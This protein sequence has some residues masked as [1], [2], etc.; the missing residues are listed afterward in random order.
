MHTHCFKSNTGSPELKQSAL[1]LAA[2]MSIFI[3][4]SSDVLTFFK[5]ATYQIKRSVSD[6]CIYLRFYFTSFHHTAELKGSGNTHTHTV[7]VLTRCLSLHLCYLLCFLVNY[8]SFIFLSVYRKRVFPGY[9]SSYIVNC[10]LHN[11][12]IICI[13]KMRAAGRFYHLLR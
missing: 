1:F 8:S 7:A 5:G 13:S 3:F 4:K 12:A 6:L 11:C 2:F 10:L 9:S